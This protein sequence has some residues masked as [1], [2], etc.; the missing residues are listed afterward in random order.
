MIRICVIAVGK[1]KERFW[2]QAAAEYE[3]RMKPLA[4]LSVIE[5]AELPAGPAGPAEALRREAA[6]IRRAVPKGA[7]LIALTPEGRELS[8][9]AFSAEI[10]RWA[11]GG[12]SR[13]CFVIGGSN[14]LA[15]ELKAEAD[16]RLSFSPMTF[17]H[18]LFRVMLLE[19]LYRAFMIA[20]GR[21]YNK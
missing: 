5:L 17:P 16:E 3:K 9:E 11:A 18:H 6:E 2:E 10:G 19:Q 20:G 21:T 12:S 15:P 7:R 4:E 1:L 8:S 13:L 14:G